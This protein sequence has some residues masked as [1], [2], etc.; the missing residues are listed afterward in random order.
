MLTADC[1]SLQPSTLKE[2]SYKNRENLHGNQEIQFQK[3]IQ[4]T[5]VQRESRRGSPHRDASHALGQA[6]GEEPQA[7][8]C[9]WSFQ[10]PAEGRQSAQEKGRLNSKT[11][12][13]RERH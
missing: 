5:Q 11:A 3:K 7:G 6:Q 10:G 4:W 2:P 1:F 13:Q 8:Y 12:F 9:H